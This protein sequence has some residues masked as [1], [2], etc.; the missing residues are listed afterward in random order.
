MIL[1][2]NK[3]EKVSQLTQLRDKYRAAKQAFSNQFEILIQYFHQTQRKPSVLGV[4]QEY[5]GEFLNDGSITDNFGAYC[6][7]MLTSAEMGSVWKGEKGTVKIVPSKNITMD[8]EVQDYFVRISDDFSS[9]LESKK[10]RF[11]VGLSSAILEKNIFGTSGL[12]CLRGDYSSPLMFQQRSV[13]NFFLGYDKDGRVDTIMFDRYDSPKQIVDKYGIANVPKAVKE[14]YQ[15]SDN[16]TK[17]V[18]T[19]FICPRKDPIVTEGKLGM[20]WAVY[21]FMPNENKFLGEGGYESF[22]VPILFGLKLEYEDYARSYAMD[23]LP[24]VIQLNVVSE[25]LAEGG[26]ATAKPPLGMYDNGTLAGKTLDLSGGALNVFNVS[27]SVPTERPIFP[28]Y[29]VGDLRV[30]FEWQQKLYEKVMQFFLLDKIY[31]FGSQQRMSVPEVGIRDAIRSDATSLNYVN[32]QNFMVEVFERGID[33]MFS[34]GLLGVADPN[35]MKDPKVRELLSN[36]RLPFQIPAKVLEAMTRGL[37]WYDFEFISP[38][39]RTMRTEALRAST[40]FLQLIGEASQLIPEFRDT[41]N[42]AGTSSKLRDLLS[43]DLVMINPP[44]IVAKIQQQRAQM[45]AAAMQMEAQ[46]A[47]AKANQSNAQAMA[48]QTGAI[49]NMQ[50]TQQAA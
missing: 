12:S 42:V 50:G 23:A 39:A 3:R 41:I 11:E 6:A 14:A 29:D 18:V 7:K 1:A 17:F 37:D 46:Q 4:S 20:P 48:A 30:M 36:G 32:D 15:K 16:K 35:N 21:E 40:T 49:R 19:E 28:L 24:T 2:D 33:I 22:P 45:Q 38:A 26:E 13:L 34:M 47:Q 31:D 27:G 5:Q 8:K 44:E 10:S 43:A 9:A 25:I